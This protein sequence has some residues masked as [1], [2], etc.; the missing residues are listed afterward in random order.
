MMMLRDRGYC[1]EKDR[2][3]DW[4]VWAGVDFMIGGFGR[5]VDFMI[6]GFGQ[7]QGRPL[8]TQIIHR[9]LQN[10]LSQK[11]VVYFLLAIYVMYHRI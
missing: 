8:R 2:F 7:A 11:C 9:N 10:K 5:A 1:Q 3:Y 4:W 6:G